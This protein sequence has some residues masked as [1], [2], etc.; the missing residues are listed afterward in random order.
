LGYA[1]DRDTRHVS[2]RAQAAK[3]ETA[4]R[5]VV[6]WSRAARGTPALRAAVRRASARGTLVCVSLDAA[7]PPAGA[8]RIARLPKSGAAWRGA[9]RKRPVLETKKIARP[10]TRPPRARHN[11]AA[12]GERSMDATATHTR[13]SRS[14][15]ILGFLAT[16]LVFGAAIGTGLYQSD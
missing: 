10:P 4:H 2:R 5:V 7:P 11:K 9:L 1:V 15:P 8:K 3:I 12:D 6:L 14:A 13:P 16:L